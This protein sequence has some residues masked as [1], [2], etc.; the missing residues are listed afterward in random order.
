[1]I[2]EL[3]R[4]ALEPYRTALPRRRIWRRIVTRIKRLKGSHW[5]WPS[6]DAWLYQHARLD[7]RPSLY[8]LVRVAPPDIYAPSPVIGMALKQILDLRVAS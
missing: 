8:E 4:E 2:D 7:P 6:M 1:M 5:S 3:L